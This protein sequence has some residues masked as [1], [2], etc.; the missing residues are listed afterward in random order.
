MAGYPANSGG[1][2]AVGPAG[3]ALAGTYP[4]PTI[5]T[6]Y[7]IP[8][9]IQRNGTSAVPDGIE[10]VFTFDSTLPVNRF[11]VVRDY[12]FVTLGAP[13]VTLTTNGTVVT[14]TFTAG[15]APLDSVSLLDHTISL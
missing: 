5:P 2:G 15:N 8:N 12:M 4:D 1:D 3:G 11:V 13:V 10:L 14:A 9:F 7:T 6:N